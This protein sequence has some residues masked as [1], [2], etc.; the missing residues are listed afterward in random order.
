MAVGGGAERAQCYLNVT[1]DP[2]LVTPP[3]TY[4]L[5][6]IPVCRRVRR[7]IALLSQRVGRTTKDV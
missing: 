4:A 5:G 3:Y 7:P 6:E 2:T 1:C